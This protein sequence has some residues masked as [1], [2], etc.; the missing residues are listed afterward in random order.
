MTKP[1]ISTDEE[2]AER[3]A[4]AAEYVV[5]T[6]SLEERLA[7]EALMATDAAMADLVASW[8]TRLAPLDDHYVEVAAPLAILDRV[9]ARL[10]PKAA[11]RRRWSAWVF[12]ALALT[13]AAVVALVYLPP[14][15][16]PDQIAATLTAEGQPLVVAALYDPGTGLLRVN[17]TE[18]PP[19]QLGKDYELWVIPAGENPISLGLLR[20]AELQITLAELPAGT[21]LAVTLEPAGGGPGGVPTGPIVAAAVITGT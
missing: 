20:D 4:R 16:A 17:R 1:P 13:S 18:G 10:F 7:T 2:M 14:N 21:T 5:G 6:L 8:Q 11:P 15:P 3:D 9:E 12:A 19:A